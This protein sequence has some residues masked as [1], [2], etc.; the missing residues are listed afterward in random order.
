MAIVVDKSGNGSGALM[1]GGVDLKY[2]T[3][4]RKL[5]EAGV[6][7]IDAVTPLYAG[8]RVLFVPTAA[9]P[10]LLYQALDLTVDGW[11]LCQLNKMAG[12]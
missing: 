8:E 4:N 5:T 12:A 10:S 6:T 9:G 11:Q 2:C 3:Y 1:P 7:S